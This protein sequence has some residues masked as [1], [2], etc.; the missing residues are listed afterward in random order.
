MLPNVIKIT[1]IEVKRLIKR[2][3]LSKIFESKIT[4]VVNPIIGK[5]KTRFKILEPIIFPMTIFP[6]FLFRAENEA[7]SSG[8][9]VP[10]AT[11]VSPMTVLDTPK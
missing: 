7:A 9:L 11:R 3:S 8:K 2:K 1:K 6:F 10:I 4:F 5:I